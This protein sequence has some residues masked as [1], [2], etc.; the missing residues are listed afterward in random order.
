MLLL[1]S[2]DNTEQIE[3]GDCRSFVCGLL[4]DDAGDAT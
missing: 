3:Y 4:G 1:V 2:S